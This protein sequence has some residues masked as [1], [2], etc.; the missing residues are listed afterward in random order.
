MSSRHCEERL[1]RSNPYLRMPRYGL[2]RGACHRA[3]IRATRWLAM[4]WISRS[5]PKRIRATRPLA[6]TVLDACRSLTSQQQIEQMRDQRDI[7]RRHWV[8]AQFARAHPRQL[9][10]LARDDRALPAPADVERHQQMEGL[11]GVAREGQRR[12]ARVAGAATHPR[13][14]TRDL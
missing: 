6:M 14:S 11:I 8:V 1:R 9:L 5:V 3:R 2:L 7:R 4:T 10:A 13:L 12:Q